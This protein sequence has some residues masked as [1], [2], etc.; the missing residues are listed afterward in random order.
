MGAAGTLAEATEV[1][2]RLLQSS[3]TAASSIAAL[4]ELRVTHVVDLS[5]RHTG[6]GQASGELVYHSCSVQDTSK[7]NIRPTLESSV[8]F[9]RR[10]LDESPTHRC[11]VHCSAGRSRSSAVVLAYLVVAQRMLLDD[12]WAL[13]LR[14]RPEARPNNG[15]VRQ[16]VA[17]HEREHGTRLGAHRIASIAAP[18]TQSMRAIT[19]AFD[20]GGARVD[21]APLLRLA[22]VIPEALAAA[23]VG[24]FGGDRQP[25]PAVLQLSD[26]AWDA[27]LLGAC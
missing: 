5:A 14:R 9:L 7:A 3:L 6:P 22:D 27:V 18:G 8:E 1:V 11:L 26:E 20:D 25:R 15:F 12:A 21:L 16:L 23:W 13:L 24:Q 2:P 4:R 17:L 10:A 19:R